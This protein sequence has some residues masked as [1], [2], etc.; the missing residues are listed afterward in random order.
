MAKIKWYLIDTERTFC[1]VWDIIITFLTMYTIFVSPF[2]L[3]FP[4][5]Y[6]TCNPDHSWKSSDC[7]TETDGINYHQKYLK[8]FE[9]TID[10]FMFVDIV[11]NFFKKTHSLT[12]L[13]LISINYLTGYF[14]FDVIAT[15]PELFM[16]QTLEYY[17]L[18]LG[19]MVHIYKLT[20]PLEILLSFVL[21]SY[22]KKR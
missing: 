7:R 16:E 8:R 4:E 2:L 12:T 3:V 9:Y 6:Q 22:S 13:K 14:I 17:Y 1:K 5:V 15:I 21:K 20:I 10:I 11:L 19:R 18:K